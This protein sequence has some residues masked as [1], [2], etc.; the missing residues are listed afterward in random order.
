MDHFS[1]FINNTAYQKTPALHFTWL[2]MAKAQEVIRLSRWV[3]SSPLLNHKSAVCFVIGN[4]HSHHWPLRR[5]G[6]GRPAVKQNN[7]PSLIFCQ[8]RNYIISNVLT[9]DVQ[10]NS[11][12]VATQQ[13]HQILC[14]SCRAERR[15]DGLSLSLSLYLWQ[16]NKCSLHRHKIMSKC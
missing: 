5:W 3:F 8:A 16:S 7:T 2:F 4:I 6:G 13:K 9:N 10:K 15:D 1:L 14:K 11:A 12:S